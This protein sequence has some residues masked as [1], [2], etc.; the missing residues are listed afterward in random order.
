[1]NLNE[2]LKGKK[3]CIC[4]RDHSCFV[5]TAVIEKG[6]LLKLPDLTREH[7]N[8]LVA[9]DKNTFGVCGGR[10]LELLISKNVSLCIFDSEKQFLVPDEKAI[11]TLMHYVK[12]DTDLIIGIGSGVIND[13]CKY[14]SFKKELPY[15]IVATAPSMD[16]FVSNVAAMIIKGMK[17]TYQ[18]HV[19]QAV[20]GDVDILKMAPMDMIK[21][22]YGDIIGKLS[23]LNDWKLG[24][25]L[26]DEYFCSYIYDLLMGA[27][28]KTV[29]LSKGLKERSEDSIKA[30]M[31]TLVL[32]GIAISY[33]GNSRPAS[34]SEH[35]LSHYFEIVSLQKNEPYFL[36]GTDVAY[37]TVVTAAM[38]EELKAFNNAPGSLAKLDRAEWIKSIREIY[39]DAGEGVIALQDEMG[40]YTKDELSLYRKHWD[41]IIAT[42]S[43]VPS[44]DEFIK[45]ISTVGLSMD[46]FYSLYG[47]EKI[48]KGKWFAKDLKDRFTFLWIYWKV[49]YKG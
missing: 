14:V 19:P 6:A 1:M 45:M 21:S 9:A 31:E 18:A 47:K 22:G 25:L 28:N 2:L 24:H 5:K 4:G 38:R 26:Y 27:V 33:N 43:L 37:S 32:S 46:E 7:K 36:H 42:L 13:L 29:G 39:K 17:V 20:I 15:F 16:G 44:A 48:E 34:G 11:D 23:S 8:V 40:R 3:G 30:L 41:E 10:V 35:H 12:E 49:L